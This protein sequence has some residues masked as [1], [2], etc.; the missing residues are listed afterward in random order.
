MKNACAYDSEQTMA[1]LIHHI[2]V[3]PF[4]VAHHRRTR[5]R[6]MTHGRPLVVEIKEVTAFYSDNESVL[7][8][9]ELTKSQDVE[10]VVLPWRRA[11]PRILKF[12]V[13]NGGTLFAHAWHRDLEF[14]HRTQEWMGGNSNRIFHKSLLQWPE[15]GCYDKNWVSI[16]RVCSLHFLMNRCPKF[17]K[18]Y[19]EWYSTLEEAKFKVHMDLQHLAQFV[20]RQNDYQESHTAIHDCRDLVAVLLEAYNSDTYKLDGHS[21]MISEKSME[22]SLLGTQVKRDAALNYPRLQSQTGP[23]PQH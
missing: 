2:C 15:T 6:V 3:I 12:V 20:Y 23:P 16:S 4:S 18:S 19:T 9:T 8:K 7:R 11:I 10:Y 1:G 21:Y 5:A 13:E 22:P 14:L 17:M